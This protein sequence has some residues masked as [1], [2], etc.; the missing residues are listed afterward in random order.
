MKENDRVEQSLVDQ[1]RLW[2]HQLHQQP[3]MGF[4]EAATSKF[5]VGKL[6]EFGFSEIFEGIGKTGVVASLRKGSSA[7]SIAL[8]ADMDALKIHE[9]T[10]LE[11]ASTRPGIMHA[12]GHDGH[13][14][15][16]L[17]AAQE[18]ALG[19]A[20]FDGCV[21]F[22]FQPAE[23]WGRGALS[24]M[25]EGVLTRFPVEEIYG[26]HNLPGLP[27][28][29]FATR[30]G[31]IMAAEDIFEIEINGQGGHAARPHHGREALVAS[32]ALVMN[33][34]SIVSRR[35]DPAEPA[36][37]SVTE[38]HTDGTRNALPGKCKISGDARSFSPKVSSEIER[39][40]RLISE[41][42][43]AS[44]G[45]EA[46]VEYRREFVPLINDENCVAHALEAATH[47]FEQDKIIQ[48][49]NP[50]TASEDFAQF[51]REVPGC[52]AFLGNGDT[53]PLH[54]AHYD[55]N[56]DALPLGAQFFVEIVRARLPANI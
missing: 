18:L 19:G 8:R 5:V 41:G 12:C 16:L 7:R 20:P 17:G 4:D 53:A 22:I 50:L 24:M 55:F 34:Q 3:E 28:G 44:Y 39:Q 15:M 1:M 38:F 33:L 10:N 31:A 45:C 43:A 27:L 54:N 35:I 30:A 25:E 46:T 21:H 13:V 37:V 52:F 14:A 26:L 42:T 49:C 56:D 29:T 32:C 2:R 23:E 36:V 11:Y 40:I 6:R 47:V 51:L 48:D 9:H